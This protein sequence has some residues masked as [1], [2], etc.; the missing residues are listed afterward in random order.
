[1]DSS[2]RCIGIAA[3]REALELGDNGLPDALRPWIAEGLIEITQLKQRELRLE[4]EIKAP[5]AHQ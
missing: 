5:G 1:M 2:C 4:R 3:M